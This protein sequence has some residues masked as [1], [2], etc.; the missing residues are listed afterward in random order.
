MTSVESLKIITSSV[1]KSDRETWSS[2][3]ETIQHRHRYDC[4]TLKKW[5]RWQFTFEEECALFE[6]IFKELT[7]SRNGA[8]HEMSKPLNVEHER[9][10]FDQ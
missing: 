3:T 10:S 9:D 7:M 2:V 4:V 6:E 5:G 1:T 8:V